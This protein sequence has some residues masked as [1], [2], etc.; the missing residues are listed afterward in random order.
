MAAALKFNCHRVLP[1]G[2]RLMP[3]NFCQCFSEKAKQTLA[4]EDLREVSSL[5]QTS[6]DWRG[7]ERGYAQLGDTVTYQVIEFAEAC[8]GRNTQ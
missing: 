1:S 5:F 2:T 3:D 6:A 7:L 4:Y 8:D